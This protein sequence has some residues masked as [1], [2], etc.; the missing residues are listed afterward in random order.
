MIQDELGLIVD[1]VKQECDRQIEAAALPEGLSSELTGRSVLFGEHPMALVVLPLFMYR[2]VGG[3]NIRD[4]AAAGAAMEFLLAAADVLDDV[5]DMTP[6]VTNSRT[7]VGTHSH[8]VTEMELLTTLLLL[9]EQSIISL[10]DGLLKQQRVARAIS[11]FNTFKLKAFVGQ[12]ADA[13][14]R[15][16]LSTDIETCLMITS[17]KSGSLGKCAAEM[18]AILGSDDKSIIELAGQYGEHLAVARQFHDD[19]ANLWPS[20]GRLDDLEQ[21]KQTLPLTY[22]LNRGE[23]GNNG[24]VHAVSSLE[25]LVHLEDAPEPTWNGEHTNGHRT[26]IDSARDEVFRDGGIHFAMLQAVINLVRARSLGRR[27]ERLPKGEGM[28]ERLASG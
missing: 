17:G 16:D 20:T 18:G 19:V 4:V 2:A 14:G 1:L 22:V 5:Q 12:Y 6:P 24:G 3:D 26:D 28:L 10:V 11:V 27:I 23:N 21:L 25:T 8:Y 15:V 13:H 7:A 9:G